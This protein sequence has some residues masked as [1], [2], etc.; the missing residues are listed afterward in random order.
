MSY[1]EIIRW[2]IDEVTKKFNEAERSLAEAKR[3][4]YKERRVNA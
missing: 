4:S 1:K 2:Y 3:L